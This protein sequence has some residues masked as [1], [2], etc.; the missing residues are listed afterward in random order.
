MDLEFYPLLNREELVFEICSFTFNTQSCQT[1]LNIINVFISGH[2]RKYLTVCGM[3]FSL[4]LKDFN[5]TEEGDS[6]N[7]HGKL[8]VCRETTSMVIKC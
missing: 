2:E 7:K 6:Q 5:Q 8:T 4:A 3:I 1:R